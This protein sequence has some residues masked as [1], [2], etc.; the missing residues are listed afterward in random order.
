M[1]DKKEPKTLQDAFKS[2]PKDNNFVN[3]ILKDV[4][5]INLSDQEITKLKVILRYETKGTLFD[6]I[7][8]IYRIIATTFKSPEK[9]IVIP[10]KDGYGSQH[11]NIQRIGY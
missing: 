5:G 2:I 3:E 9:I 8:N 7:A 6:N 11:L 4:T 1:K 10:F